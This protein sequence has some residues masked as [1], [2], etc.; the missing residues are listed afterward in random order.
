MAKHCTWSI[1]DYYANEYDL[2]KMDH[3]QSW[4]LV[5]KQVRVEIK[6]VML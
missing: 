4:V 2:K 6:K 1:A 3:M 5:A